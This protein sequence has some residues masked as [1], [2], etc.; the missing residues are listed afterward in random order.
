MDSRLIEAPQRKAQDEFKNTEGGHASQRLGPQL[1]G[2]IDPP[3]LDKMEPSHSYAP[4]WHNRLLV[5][6]ETLN[7]KEW[8][9]NGGENLEGWNNDARHPATLRSG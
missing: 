5:K 6:F 3:A 9:N 1:Q 8:W 4:D 7:D 2:G